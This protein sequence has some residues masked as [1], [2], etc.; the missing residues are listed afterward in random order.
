M[1]VCSKAKLKNVLVLLVLNKSQVR[2]RINIE[3]APHLVLPQGAEHHGP[4]DKAAAE[5]FHVGLDHIIDDLKATKL[6]RKEAPIPQLFGQKMRFGQLQVGDQDAEAGEGGEEGDN[7]VEKEGVDEREAVDGGRY[8]EEGEDEVEDGEPLVLLHLA[9][10]C[11]GHKERPAHEG[12]RIEEDEARDVEDGVTE[13]QLEC[14]PGLKGSQGERRQ[15][16][17]CR[18]PQ[19]RPHRHSIGTLQGYCLAAGLQRIILKSDLM[20][21]G[22]HQRDN[23]RGD[24]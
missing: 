17:G 24:H 16:A 23:G 2:K 6:T 3:K 8:E 22:A 20:Q 5:D 11:L 14:K 1:K 19:V 4:L 21:D 12:E 10:Q 15:D 18:C 7:C 9:P 13:S